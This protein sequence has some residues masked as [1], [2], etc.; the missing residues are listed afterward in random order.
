MVLV[1]CGAGHLLRQPGDRAGAVARAR[2]W[3]DAHATAD[4]R[5]WLAAGL[6]GNFLSLRMCHVFIY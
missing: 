2:A 3:A 5:Q 1:S 4:V 6:D